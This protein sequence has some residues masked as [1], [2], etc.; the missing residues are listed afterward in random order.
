MRLGASVRLASGAG[1]RARAVTPQPAAR[2]EAARPLRP[3]EPEPGGGRRQQGGRQAVRCF[4]NPV[5]GEKPD[6]TVPDRAP[7]PYAAAAASSA[8]VTASMMEAAV[9][10]MQSRDSASVSLLP[11]YIWM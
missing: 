3:R 11:W 8:A 10:W 5:P 6:R 7:A 4:P 1:T 9:F 2:M